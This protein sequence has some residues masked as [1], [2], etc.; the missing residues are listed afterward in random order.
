MVLATSLAAHG[1]VAADADGTNSATVAAPPAAVAAMVPRTNDR[2]PGSTGMGEQL[3]TVYGHIGSRTNGV[4]SDHAHTRS[5]DRWQ[6]V[7]SC[8]PGNAAA[9]PA[10]STD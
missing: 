8:R 3:L 2:L 10:T 9:N 6:P 7:P 5:P 4:S 1:S